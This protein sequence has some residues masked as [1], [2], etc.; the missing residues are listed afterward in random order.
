MFKSLIIHHLEMMKM[1]EKKLFLFALSITFF[2]ILAQNAYS[3]IIYCPPPYATIYA[4]NY[5]NTTTSVNYPIKLENHNDFPV[6]IDITKSGEGSSLLSITETSFVLQPSEVKNI[7]VVVNLNGPA[8]TSGNIFFSWSDDAGESYN[9]VCEVSIGINGRSTPIPGQQC[10]SS[11]TSCGTYPDCKNLKDITQFP[12]CVNGKHTNYWCSLNVIKS[13]NY[14]DSACCGAI[15]GTCQNGICAVN[16]PPQKSL[17]LNITNGGSPKFASISLFTPGTNNLITNANI[18]G[19][20]TVGYSNSTADFKV[21]YDSSKLS[22]LLKNF[23]L[24]NITTTSNIV[25]DSISPSI[26]N[27][28]LR[29]AYKISVPS[30]FTTSSTGIVLTMKYSDLQVNENVLYL[31]RCGN[32]NFVTNICNDTWAKISITRDVMNDLVTAE[33]P[34]FSAYAL[35]EGADVVT[36]TTSTTTTTIVSSSSGDSGSPSGSPG[37]SG[38][39]GGGGGGGFG[40]T[41]TSITTTTVPTTTT[42]APVTTTTQTVQG[43]QQNQGPSIFTGFTSLTSNNP[44]WFGLPAAAAAGIFLSWK[45]YFKTRLSAPSYGRRGPSFKTKKRKNSKDTKLVFQ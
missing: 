12:V 23:Y 16:Q 17:T 19:M 45:F 43:S 35:G 6:T 33:V 36:T 24:D 11:D 37:G 39:G 30:S 7:N 4:N 14:C 5:P 28:T 9:D 10:G 18:T 32:F 25:L 44:I 21:D 29:R 15:G 20:G 22:F 1:T 3:M 41:S 8:Y 40:T 13:N 31:Y 38:G 34:G 27:V 26:P 2:F 42:A